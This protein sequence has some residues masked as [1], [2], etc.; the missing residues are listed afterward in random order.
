MAE[1]FPLAD[2]WWFYLGFTAFVLLMLALDLGVFHRE[3]HEVSFKEAATWSVVWVALALGF[4]FFLYQ[5]ALWKFPP[6]VAWRVALEFLTGYVVEKSLSVDNVFVFV[7]VFGY[8]AVPAKYQHRV[9]F[10]GIIGALAFRAVFIAL[11][12]ALMQY[13]WVVILFGAFLIITGVRMMFTPEKGVEPEKNPLIRLLRR[14]VPTT[15]ELRGQR[16]F[17]RERGVLHATPLFVALLFLEAT[18]V[19][20]AVDSV[21]AIFALT[22]E[23]LVVFTSNVFAILGLRAMYFM[24]AGAMDKFHM[25]KYGLAVVLVFVGLKMVWLN[26]LYGGKFPISISL[27]VIAGVIALS[28]LLSLAFPKA[29]AEVEGRAD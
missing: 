6:D 23:P 5:Y 13:H 22:K 19:I 9:L 27:G 14:L 1:L 3:A 26:G 18:D 11:G 8:F 7:L 15:Q 28:V 21:P 2:Y 29:R 25:L 16:F 20:F 4:N 12:S 24:L 10:Y 17:V